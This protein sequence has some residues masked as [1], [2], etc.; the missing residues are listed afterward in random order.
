MAWENGLTRR[1]ARTLRR[2]AANYLLALEL[3]L[4]GIS[5]SEPP[6]PSQR[7]R[8]YVLCRQAIDDMKDA[9]NKLRRIESK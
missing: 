4:R 2:M 7:E 1:Q 3:H 8:P 5:P 6:R 9:I